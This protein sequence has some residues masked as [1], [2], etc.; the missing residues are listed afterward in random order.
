MPQDTE[1][2]VLSDRKLLPSSFYHK[3]GLTFLGVTILVG[4][5]YTGYAYYAA[6]ILRV[7]QERANTEAFIRDLMEN[8]PAFTFQIVPDAP[9]MLTMPSPARN[10]SRAVLSEEFTSARASLQNLGDGEVPNIYDLPVGGE[11]YLDYI[12]ELPRGL[13]DPFLQMLSEIDELVATLNTSYE[14]ITLANRV[15]E[16]E[17]LLFREA[18]LNTKGELSVYPSLRVAHAHFAAEVLARQFPSEANFYREYADQF[19]Q[20]GVAF[21]HYSES[22][23][24]LTE[25]LIDDYVKAAEKNELGLQV[26]QSFEQ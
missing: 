5:V 10:V 8:A 2:Q 23:A 22:D 19:I 13:Q 14:Q 16:D 1:A 15:G 26:L 4:L 20:S 12:N 6:P 25:M 11:T 7:E 18:T 21:G 9:T 17:A 24:R 3:V